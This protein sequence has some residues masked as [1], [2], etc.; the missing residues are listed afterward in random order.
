MY[1]EYEMKAVFRRQ[2]MVMRTAASS[3]KENNHPNE[4]SSLV[5]W[6]RYYPL[7]PVTTRYYPLL[8]VITARVLL[9]PW[10]PRSRHCTACCFSFLITSIALM[11][12]SLL[13]I[14]STSGELGGT[15]KSLVEMHSIHRFVVV[16][17]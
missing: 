9:P 3:S 15:K 4:D 12:H 1:N 10:Q 6:S 8:P 2:E 14:G 17:F 11:F 7:L 16:M 5:V 13:I